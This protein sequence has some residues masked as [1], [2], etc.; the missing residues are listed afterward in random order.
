MESQLKSRKRIAN[1][2]EVFTS[3]REVNA[4][5]DLVKTETER[6]ESRFLEPACGTGNFLIAVLQRKLKVIA[7]VFAG[8]QKLAERKIWIAFSGMYGVDFLLDNTI[9]C[10]AR[11]FNHFNQ[12]YSE[13]YQSSARDTF[14]NQIKTLIAENI[15][16]GDALTFSHPENGSPLVFKKWPAHP[17]NDN[18]IDAFSIDLTQYSHESSPPFDV[19]LG[20]PP[21]QKSDGGAQASA[22]PLYHYFVENAIRLNPK[23]LTMIIPS[24]WFTSGKGLESFRA[25][26]LNDKRI[27]TLVDFQNAADCF[28]G[29]EIKGGVCYF[30]WSRD[31]PGPCEVASIDR[32]GKKNI[33][34]RFLREKNADIF[35][36]YNGAVSILKKIQKH[37]EDSFNRYISARKPFGLS[38]SLDGIENIP[39]ENSIPIFANKK[40]G[41][42]DRSR[43]KRNADWIDSYKLLVPYAIGSGDSLTDH[44]KSIIAPPGTCCTETYLVFGPFENESVTKNVN[45]YIQTKF[46]HF[47]LTLKKNTQHATSKAYAFVPTQDFKVIWDDAKLYKKYN[48]TS[49]EVQLIE[50]IVNPNIARNKANDIL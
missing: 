46:F 18:A 13:W 12:V 16:W 21:Y 49:D 9:E 28:P 45:S 48:L 5:L 1:H 29:V 20:N 37:N 47:L 4:M 3:F 42:I 35:I 50:A 7:D 24:R 34:K 2:G 32:L 17:G 30:L 40:V 44:I 8:D 39:S 36:R 23:Y 6:I 25:S 10:R 33:L 19:I 27:R 41:F 26:M 43:I 15:L 38:T 14:R 11:L 31:K 22:Q